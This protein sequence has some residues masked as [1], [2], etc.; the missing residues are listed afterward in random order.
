M[1]SKCI[2][3]TAIVVMAFFLLPDIL[4]AANNLLT[5]PDAETGNTQGWTDP[6]NAWIANSG[7]VTIPPHGGDYFFSPQLYLKYTYMYQ[8]VDISTYISDIDS[9]KAYL[10]LSGWLAN[11]D[12]YP[13]DQATLA[14]EARDSNNNQLLYLTRTHRSPTWTFYK[15]QNLIPVNSR[16][17][18]VSLIA[19]R[20]VGSYNDA[21]F[22]DLSLSVTNTAPISSVTVTS[23]DGKTEVLVGGTLQ[24]S[25]TT[26]GGTGSVE[27]DIIRL[28]QLGS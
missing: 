28:L 27:W 5:N 4:L 20:F 17:L 2:L 15:I 6:D 3:F 26:S 23:I 19:N 16:I 22:D 13:H 9:G 24:L 14:I 25:A 21:Y 18:R 7:S 1:K 8:D 12:Q 11:Y 10:E